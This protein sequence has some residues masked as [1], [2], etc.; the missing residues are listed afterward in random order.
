[1]ARRAIRREQK[2]PTLTLP[3]PCEGEETCSLAP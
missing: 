2:R 1:M 3:S